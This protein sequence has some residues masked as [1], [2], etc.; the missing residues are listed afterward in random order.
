MERDAMFTERLREETKEL[1]LNAIEV[2]G[3]MSE[4]D[5]TAAVAAIFGL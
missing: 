1:G 4:N 2:D 3:S 5:L